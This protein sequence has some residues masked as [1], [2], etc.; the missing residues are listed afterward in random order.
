M[1]VGNLMTNAE[2]REAARQFIQK[3]RG[4]GNEKQES[5]SYWIDLLSV[6][7]IGKVT[8]YVQFERPVI[9]NRQQKYIDAYMP[10]VRVMVSFSEL[11][12]T[13]T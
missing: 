9:V 7:G 12:I 6:L 2:Q 8:D 4:H 5:Q 10:S 13:E 3:W 11:L 1:G